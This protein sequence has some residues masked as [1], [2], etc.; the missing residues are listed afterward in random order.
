MERNINNKE[1]YKGGDFW[2]VY[3]GYILS[4]LSVRSFSFA[5]RPHPSFMF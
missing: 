2:F 1:S 4:A 3:M 5:S